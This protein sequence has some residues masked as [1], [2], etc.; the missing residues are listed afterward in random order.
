VI[1]LI[2]LDEKCAGARSAGNPHAAC[3]AEGAG[4]G[5][6]DRPRRA[7]RGKPRRQT[8]MILRA[9]APVL[10][11][12]GVFGRHSR[13]RVYGTHRSWRRHGVLGSHTR[14]SFSICAVTGLQHSG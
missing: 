4:N 2:T 12:T 14:H 11:P 13:H 9:A 3:E 7:R 8:R 6:T 1:G 10:D 5:A